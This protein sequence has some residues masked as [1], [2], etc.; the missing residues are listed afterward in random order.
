[1]NSSSQLYICINYANWK[2]RGWTVDAVIS[3]Y[4]IE[5]YGEMRVSEIK[6]KRM[7]T[8]HIHA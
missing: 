1:M 5:I 7:K 2:K 8:G 3:C 4:P 6:K